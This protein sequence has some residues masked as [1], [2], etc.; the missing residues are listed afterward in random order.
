MSSRLVPTR[1]AGRPAMDYTGI[2]ANQ[3]ESRIWILT[4][5]REILERHISTHREP[6]AGLPAAWPEH[7]V[8]GMTPCRSWIWL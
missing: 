7:A 8:A 3:R 5:K 4:E 2:D 6:F 1:H